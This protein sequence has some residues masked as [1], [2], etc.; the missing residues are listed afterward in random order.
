VT[1]K[2]TIPAKYSEKYSSTPIDPSFTIV[3][4]PE[5]PIAK[6]SRKYAPLP[7][8]HKKRKLALKVL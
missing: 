4:L 7:H 2:T 8:S 1:L 6:T 5:F 3:L